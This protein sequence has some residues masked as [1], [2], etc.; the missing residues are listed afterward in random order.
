VLARGSLERFCRLSTPTSQKIGTAQDSK[1][2]DTHPPH[3]PVKTLKPWTYMPERNWR[4]SFLFLVL[5]RAQT[6]Y[7]NGR[8]AVSSTWRKLRVFTVALRTLCRHTRILES[9][10]DPF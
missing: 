10:Q 8:K 4:N 6:H 9:P 7:K 1:L 5:E 2:A 3:N